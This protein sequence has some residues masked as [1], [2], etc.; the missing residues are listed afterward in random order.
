VGRAPPAEIGVP[1]LGGGR[2]LYRERT[3]RESR[4]DET[5][6]GAVSS[7]NKRTEQEWGF[8]FKPDETIMETKT[9]KQRVVD[10]AFL[11]I[12]KARAWLIQ[13]ILCMMYSVLSLYG[14]YT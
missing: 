12:I 5:E 4:E 10:F 3:A 6:Q 2:G 11:S 9:D 8:L 14:Y 7:V 13:Y 1:D